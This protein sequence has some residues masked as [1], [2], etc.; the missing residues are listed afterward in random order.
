MNCSIF[1]SPEQDLLY[2]NFNQDYRCE[3][4]LSCTFNL[5]A[6]RRG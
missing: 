6:V 5:T 2:A 3:T 4:R 1:A